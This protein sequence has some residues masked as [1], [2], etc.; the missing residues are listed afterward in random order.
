MQ[1]LEGNYNTNI[2]RHGIID[3]TSLFFKYPNNPFLNG[4]TLRREE[5]NL[6]RTLK[7]PN[8]PHR[9]RFRPIIELHIDNNICYVTTSQL[10]FEALDEQISN[11]IPFNILPEEWKSNELIKNFG[12]NWK[13][14]HDKWLDDEVEN[15][16]N[17]SG[18]YLLRNITGIDGINIVKTPAVIPNKNVGEI[19]F[20]IIDETKRTVY[21]VDTKCIKV[22]KQHACISEDKSKFTGGKNHMMNNCI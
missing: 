19:D 6:S 9:I 16:L 8:Y 18:Y 1:I 10:V 11:L 5:T 17:K 14:Q 3:I 22:K 13:N 20:I 21:V 15:I 2:Q 12:K 4:L 7:N